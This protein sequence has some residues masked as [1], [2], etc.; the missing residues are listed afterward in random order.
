MASD[1]KKRALTQLAKLKDGKVDKKLAQE[2]EKI[3]KALKKETCYEIL[4]EHIELL[5]VFAFR[6]HATAFE[7][8][9]G[10]LCRLEKMKLTYQQVEG[11]PED[12]HSRFQNA[13]TLTLKIFQIL[14]KIRYLQFEKIFDLFLEYAQSQNE[15]IKKEATQGLRLLAEY[16]FHVYFSSDKKEDNM[17]GLG[18]EPQKKLIEK[19]EKFSLAKKKKH[20]FS[21]IL[22]C[23]KFLKPTA[24]G[25]SWHANSMTLHTATLPGKGFILDV[26]EKTISLLE[27]LFTYALDFESK[28]SVLSALFEATRTPHTGKLNQ[29]TEEMI[30]AN[31]IAVL[32]FFYTLLST[33]NNQVK[34]ELETNVYWSFQHW[35]NKEIKKIALKIKEKL[36]GDPEYQIFK[37]LIGYDHVFGDW[38]KERD[39][40]DEMEGRNEAIKK[41]AK[42]VSSK[43]QLEWKERIFSYS[44]MESKDGATFTYFSNFLEE[45]GKANP[46]FVLSLL[47]NNSEEL[48]RFLV[49]PMLGLWQSSKKEDA[50]NLVKVWIKDGKY[51]AACARVYLYNNDPDEKTLSEILHQAVNSKDEW[52]IIQVLETSLPNYSSSSKKAFKEIFLTA[53]KSLATIGSTSWINSV[54]WRKEFEGFIDEFDKKSTQIILK[55]L[56]P[57]KSIRHEAEGVLSVI[58]TKYPAL[59]VEFFGQRLE[60]EKKLGRDSIEAVPFEFYKLNEPLSKIPAK[61][62][63]IVLK[64]FEKDPRLFQFRGGMFLKNIFKTFPEDF[65]KELTSLVRTKKKEKIEFVME[66]LRNYEGEIFLHEICKEIVKVLPVDKRMQGRVAIILQSTGVVTGEFGFAEAWQQKIDEIQNWKKDKN[67]KVKNFAEKYILDVSAMVKRERQKAEEEIALR[68]HQYGEE[69]KDS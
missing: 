49:T 5:D 27:E 41:L 16:N 50:K 12:Y 56:L 21:L 38:E 33:A 31:T 57:V 62:V 9:D 51:L 30:A 36:D 25:S 24:E 48:E 53:A 22:L 64:W 45:L 44:Q 60:N 37:T 8:L 28:K 47:E 18:P 10:L 7:M 29:D 65:E 54:W 67:T 2:A 19:I 58:A 35:T 26:R 43:N 23:Q 34:Q 1:F 61:A 4:E 17:W 14:Q 55:S 66:I 39:I 69:N 46:D 32:N 20:F 63:E 59:V 52:A 6:V 3:A 11:Y 42:N 68:K 13:E 40:R 15:N